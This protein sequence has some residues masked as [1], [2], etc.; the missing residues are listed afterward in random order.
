LTAPGQVGLVELPV[1]R[2]DHHEVVIAVERRG[3]CGS[4]IHAYH[5]SHPFI[6]PPVVLGHEFAGR[7]VQLGSDVEGLAEDQP[8]TVEP[9]IVCGECFNCRTGRYNICDALKVIGCTTDGGFAEYVAVPAEKVIP[10]PDNMSMD[11][12]AMVEPLAVAY[13][14]LRVAGFEPGMK[15]AVLGAG[16]IGLV[17]LLALREQG[18]DL[19]V[20]TDLRDAKLELADRLGAD[21]TLR[22]DDEEAV[23]K[24]REYLGRRADV[25]FDCVT[26]R[27]SLA[28]AIA[29]AEKGGRVVVEG[30]PAGEVLVPLHL[31]QDRE[32]GLQGTLMYVREDFQAAVDAI[33]SGRVDVEPLITDRYPLERVADAFER[34]E[35]A[36]D[37]VVKVQIT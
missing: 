35:D 26:N 4:D 23:T 34:I 15:V 7:I 29:L 11:Q 1:P 6:D 32:I 36:P 33:G 22:G 14:A 28:Q 10:L 21:L 12:G 20:V 37:E 16:T 31:V 13:H 2:P 5:G 19:T 24:A 25:V 18:A 8:V 3:I 30:V 27:A 17:T 9:S